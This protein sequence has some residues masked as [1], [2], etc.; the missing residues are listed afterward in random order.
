[1]FLQNFDIPSGFCCKGNYAVDVK[2]I[3]SNY[4]K[5]DPEL[6]H[7]LGTKISLYSNIYDITSVQL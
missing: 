1:M 2:I 4:Y 5:V 3:M 6:M 7:F